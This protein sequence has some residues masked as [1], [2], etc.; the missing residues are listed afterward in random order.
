VLSV[1]MIQKPGDPE[2]TFYRGLNV[3]VVRR[4]LFYF[5]FVFS[6]VRF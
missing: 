4:F 5:F 3:E 2:I 1:L 6:N